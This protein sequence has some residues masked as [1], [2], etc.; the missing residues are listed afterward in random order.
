MRRALV[1]VAVCLVG[2]SFAC[3]DDD[4]GP[5][6]TVDP[7]PATGRWYGKLTIEATKR[8]D[9]GANPA[10]GITQSGRE[11]TKIAVE[12]EVTEE[13]NRT[14]MLTGEQWQRQDVHI[15]MPCYT[16]YATTWG[17]ASG[18]STGNG[19]PGLPPGFDAGFTLPTSAGYFPIVGDGEG[20]FRLGKE[21]EYTTVWVQGTSTLYQIAET[22]E[23]GGV[24][25]NE[26]PI[27]GPVDTMMPWNEVRGSLSADKKRADGSKRLT[28][29][30]QEEDGETTYD[31]TWSLKREPPL[32]AKVGGPYSVPRGEKVTLDGSQ[33]RGEI[34]EYIWKISPGQDCT[35]SDV[36]GEW[37]V[38]G[39]TVEKKGKTV[40]F[41]A[42]CTVDVRLTVRG[43]AGEDSDHGKAKVTPRAWKIQNEGS[44]AEV[45][46][47][48]ET[49]TGGSNQ[50]AHEPAGVVSGHYLHRTQA[51]PGYTVKRVEDPEGPFDQELY[52]DAPNVR[53]KRREA[54]NVAYVAPAGSVYAATGA[55]FNAQLEA[56]IRAHEKAHSDL[57][58]GW[59]AAHRGRRDPM[60]RVEK[61]AGKD[62]QQLRDNAEAILSEAESE[63]C[64]ATQHPSVFR[65]L[66]QFAGVSGT[67]R[68][69]S[70]DETFVPDLQRLANDDVTCP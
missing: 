2:T 63:L 59:L 28:R 1:L 22:C 40:T 31:I 48:G 25:E 64:R 56:Q 8:V 19:I 53:F 57:L 52:L 30:S 23:D 13:G 37:P 16:D 3:D 50:C 21:E 6:Q 60:I 35:N 5:P 11:I 46:D 29:G 20:G 51:D 10:P 9:L 12:V 42:L 14:E 38:A 41:V 43:R 32:V 67:V 45:V 36:P 4:D 66:A 68:N 24:F 49:G 18:R 7:D 69:S 39:K 33:S 15:S 26:L 17:E 44:S 58:L 54:I 27:D 61:L 34:D 47:F 65:K 70:G 62:E 55:P